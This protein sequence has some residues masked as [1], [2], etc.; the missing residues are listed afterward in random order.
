M[1]KKHF[2]FFAAFLSLAVLTANAQQGGF[3]GAGTQ[4]GGGGSGF[5]GPG[6]APTTVAQARNMRDDA[7][8]ILRGR[9]TR[10]LGD[11]KYT[12]TDNT[13]S[14]TVEIDRRAWGNVSVGENDMVEISGEV[15][16]DR[17]GVEIEV[18]SIRRL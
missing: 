9:I 1:N 18:R 13:G 16:R 4:S 8:V 2:I 12:F 17:F 7:P 3:Q 6:A 14:I 11:E 10:F 5:T 15:D